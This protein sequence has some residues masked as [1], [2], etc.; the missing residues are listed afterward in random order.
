MT[1]NIFSNF[2]FN[3]GWT[4]E[5]FYRSKIIVIVFDSS[6]IKQ[7]KRVSFKSKKRR[8]ITINLHFKSRKTNNLN[9]PNSD[10]VIGNSNFPCVKVHTEIS[11]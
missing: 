3:F 11:F 2:K 8:Y 4:V 9:T 6:R 10:D 7:G 1:L 5:L